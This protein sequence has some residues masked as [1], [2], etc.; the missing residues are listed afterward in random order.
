MVKLQNVWIWL[1]FSVKCG[2][3]LFVPQLSL[4][5]GTWGTYIKCPSNWGTYLMFF[6]KTP[7]GGPLQYFLFLHIFTYFFTFF[8]FVPKM[9][10]KSGTFFLYLLYILHS[11]LCN[12]TPATCP[13]NHNINILPSIPWHLPPAQ[14][15]ITLTS[16]PVYHDTCHLPSEP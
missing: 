2:R 8:N 14:W 3:L 12:L 11:S 6:T 15:T 9:Y 7:K 13:V 10:K 5:W 1:H 16:C 4:R